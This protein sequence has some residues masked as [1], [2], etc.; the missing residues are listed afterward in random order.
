MLSR[1]SAP[2]YEENGGRSARSSVPNPKKKPKEK[3]P[4]ATKKKGKGGG[5][6]R[7]KKKKEFLARMARGRRA[8]A[9]KGGSPKKKTTRSAARKPG[10]KKGARR[11]ASRGGKFLTARIG[12]TKRRTYLKGTKSGGARKVPV[13]EILG[14]KSQRAMGDYLNDSKT[15]PKK[16]EQLRKK[17]NSVY[18]RR[19]R[20]SDRVLRH[21][22]A[23]TPNARV[24]PFEEW[25]GKMTPNKKRTKAERSA[26]A[27]K[28]ARTRK[29]NAAKGQHAGKKTT[30]KAAKRRSAGKRSHA[31]YVAAGKKAARTRKRKSKSG[32]P[33]KR[34][35]RKAAKRTH[36]TKRRSAGKR[37]HASYAAAARKAART[38]KRNAKKGYRKN[39][40]GSYAENRRHHR[41]FK[42]N[43]FMSYLKDGAMTGLAVLGGFLGHKA[44][45]KVINDYG[46]SKIS[47]LNSG[48]VA[49]WRNT[50]GGL[51]T[52]LI[53]VPV[54]FAAAPASTAAKV[55]GGVAASFFHGLIVT[56]LTQANQ[57]TVA[58]Y[59]AAY[60]D[61]NDARY[62]YGEYVLPYAGYGEYI[63][64]SGFGDPMMQAAAGYGDSMLSQ[65]AA[66]YGDP[67]MMQ[68]AA[69]YGAA[70]MLAQA[71][72]GTG[73]YVVQGV[74]GIGEY[75]LTASNGVGG[76][77]YTD[78]GI[79]GGNVGAAE[80]ALNVSE[81][82]AG[83][84]DLPLQSI[85]DPIGLTQQI[86][87]TPSG[88]RAGVMWG[89][90]GIFGHGS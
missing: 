19:K 20:A 42:A 45:T 88:A 35:T 59:F 7:G 56:A 40:S 21:G 36:A 53:G 67:A 85:V 48:A 65:A 79:P 31:S 33:K 44:L 71:A 41:R 84:G 38:R 80:Y 55:A 24:V 51:L 58:G 43:A 28:A 75:E 14:F 52:A 62:G 69:G 81:A 57:P 47:Y 12:G 3:R 64:T 63:A 8:A 26:A 89:Q 46:L 78:E 6:L 76:F 60:P 73:E 5:K 70:P 72:A 11:S 30:R 1:R 13:Y 39:G 66:G 50:I 61:A 32:S 4:M 49:P 9:R 86:P 74:N 16:V 82:A 87:D 15:P 29:R 18:T 22:D 10:P 83:F 2:R 27:R 37:S 77:G 17:L 23:F 54:A 34:T 25:S 90:D 68:A